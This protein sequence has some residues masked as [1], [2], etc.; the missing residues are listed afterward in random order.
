MTPVDP[1]ELTA[2]VRRILNRRPAV[3]LAVGVV[4]HGTLTF[5]HAHGEA[6]IASHTPI[7]EETV[8]RVASITKTFTAIALMQLW[9]RGLVD[10]DAPANSYLRA[11]QLIPDKAGHRPATVRHLL[12]HTSGVS[13]QLSALGL[14]RPDFGET[15][16]TGQPLPTLAAYYKKGLRLHAEPGT[17]FRYT[18]HGI[19]ALGQI[20]EDVSGQPLAGYLRE[21]VFQTLGMTSTELVRSDAV[22]A[23]LATGYR[24]GSRGPRAVG[25]RDVVTAAAGAA[26][27]TA[28]DMARYL[29]ALLGG[30]GNEH[31]SVLKPATLAMM[32]EAH[33]QPDPR[34]PGMGLGFFRVNAGGHLVVE[35]QGI[36]PGFDSQ[37]LAAPNDGVGVMA[38]TN[39]ARG[40]MLWLPT[41]AG[42][43]LD[44]LLGVPT[45]GIRSDV[46]QRPDVWSEIYGWYSLPGPMAE[47]RTRS[48]I[49]AGVEVF[50][51]SGVLTLRALSPI[52][53]LYHGF[54]LHPDDAKDP[55]AFRIDL[56]RYGVGSIRVVFGREPET[57][58]MLVHLDVMPLTARKQPARTNPRRWAQGVAALAA[59][60]L[61]AR[62]WRT[63]PAGRPPPSSA[64]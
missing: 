62:A 3:G 22:K 56:S 51:R 6:D 60:S 12:T 57:G 63:R 28:S 13:E 39:G 49:G 25:E 45:Q 33:Y 4:R 26:Y 23:R 41:E 42:R 50:V 29:A 11:F 55:Y 18:D 31:G 32:F 2:E 48:I 47:A 46:A 5:F 58:T 1:D 34:M 7:S 9:E 20:V 30:G 27:S 61:V 16:K 38:F 44:T 53:L 8:F 37:I 21:H 59:T 15:V 24:L 36:L 14:L 52:P 64:A 40:A 35:H 54:A 17:R 10:L 19:A 43:L